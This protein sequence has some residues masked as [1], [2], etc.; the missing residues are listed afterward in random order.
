MEW[1][2]LSEHPQQPK[3]CEAANEQL[4]LHLEERATADEVESN[5]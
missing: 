1:F 2:V 5:S 4:L 3:E